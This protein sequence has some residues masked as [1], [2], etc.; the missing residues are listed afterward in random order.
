MEKTLRHQQRDLT[1]GLILKALSEI[2]AS[3]QFR[4]FTTEDLAER[5]GVS[6]ATIYRHFPDRDTLLRE[7]WG[8]NAGVT[9]HTL[10]T[11]VYR[12]PQKIEPDPTRPQFI[13]TVRGYGYRLVEGT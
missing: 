11:H 10:E 13:L 5:S 6:A 4:N 9:A 1:R 3:G 7:V 2:L 12:L 8:Y